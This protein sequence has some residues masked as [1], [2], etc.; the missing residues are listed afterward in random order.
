MELTYYFNYDAAFLQAEKE[1]M[2]WGAGN[3]YLHGR[4]RMWAAEPFIKGRANCVENSTFTE[5][6]YGI[7]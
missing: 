1:F 7:P 5:C 3:D 2:D 6:A 4:R